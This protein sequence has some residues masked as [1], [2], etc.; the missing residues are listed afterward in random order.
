MG[1]FSSQIS[2]NFTNILSLSWVFQ[3]QLG[4]QLII[5]LYEARLFV[6]FVCTSEI[7]QTGMLQIVILDLFGSSRGG[8]VRQL[9]SMTCNAKILEYWMISSLKI[10]LNRSWKSRR[11]WNVPLVLLE[12]SWW[13]GCNGIYLVRFWIQNVGD[14]DLKVISATEHSNEFQ[15]TRFWKEKS[16]DYVVTLGGQ[17]HR[18][19]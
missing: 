11:N 7:H 1:M 19:H 15:K 5:S 8:W 13:V 3:T 14:I 12:R 16:F 6:C 17:R 9:G 4:I 2:Q 18:P 10:R